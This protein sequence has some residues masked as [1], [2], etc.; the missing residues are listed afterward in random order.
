MTEVMIVSSIMVR[1]SEYK[2]E[3][4]RFDTRDRPQFYTSLLPHYPKIIKL[5]GNIFLPWVVCMSDMVTLGGRG[6]NLDL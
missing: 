5:I 2:I 3:D 4:P 1:T 6:S